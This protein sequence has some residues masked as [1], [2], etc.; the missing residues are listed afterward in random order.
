MRFV[1]HK[2]LIRLARTSRLQ[3]VGFKIEILAA[4]QAFRVVLL[5]KGQCRHLHARLRRCHSCLRNRKCKRSSRL[6][7]SLGGRA[8]CCLQSGS[9]PYLGRVARRQHGRMMGLVPLSRTLERRTCVPTLA[10]FYHGLDSAMLEADRHERLWFCN[11]EKGP[12]WYLGSL[13]K[14]GGAVRTLGQISI[15]K[16]FSS[17]LRPCMWVYHGSMKAC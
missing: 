10:P 8:A 13:L 6:K 11:A 14:V 5:L 15:H 9:R 2:T 7:K 16:Q 12:R 17:E 4:I 1:L 3:G